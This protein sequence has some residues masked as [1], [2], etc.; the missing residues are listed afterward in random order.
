MSKPMGG[1]SQQMG[2]G[3]TSAFPLSDIADFNGHKPINV[4]AGIVV[5]AV[6]GTY[7]DGAYQTFGAYFN[8]QDSIANDYITTFLCGLTSNPYTTTPCGL[9]TTYTNM[10]GGIGLEVRLADAQY[11]AAGVFLNNASGTS[12]LIAPILA[13]QSCKMWDTQTATL[14]VFNGGL[15]IQQQMSALSLQFDP[16]AMKHLY[17]YDDGVDT[18]TYVTGVRAG[19]GPVDPATNW[20]SGL[21]A[22]VGDIFVCSGTRSFQIYDANGHWHKLVF[23]DTL[24]GITDVPASL[25]IAGAVFCD[26]SRN[27]TVASVTTSSG[28]NI[29]SNG[30]VT[31]TTQTI[32]N[33]GANAGGAVPI[34]KPLVFAAG[35]TLKAYVLLP[36]VA[37]YPSRVITLI[38]TGAT[39]LN[40]VTSTG[41]AT[42]LNNAVIPQNKTAQFYSN[43]TSWYMALMS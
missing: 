40:V 3:K 14:G 35:Q 11:A 15:K 25:T 31:E 7:I 23:V 21:Y 4:G 5:N 26:A 36:A 6:G 12:V 19:T 27:I 43:G 20:P 33:P 42:P 17:V 30:F 22:A 37:T 13:T 24:S 18:P 28:T 16:I 8:A 2:A 39:S 1:Q 41:G 38:N 32:A 29:D 10:P 34:T 9:Q